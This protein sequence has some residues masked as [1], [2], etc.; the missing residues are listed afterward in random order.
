MLLA[1]NP[2]DGSDIFIRNFYKFASD[3]VPPRKRICCELPLYVTKCAACA[4][5]ALD[6][7]SRVLM[8]SVI[9]YVL[10]L[11]EKRQLVFTIGAQKC[12]EDCKR[13][14]GLNVTVRG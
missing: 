9:K 8:G 3:Y 7:L 13:V 1:L 14:I 12:R 11:M 2:Q 10:I 5:Y 4:I 6:V